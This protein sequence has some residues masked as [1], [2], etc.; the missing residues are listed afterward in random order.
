MLSTS[1]LTVRTQRPFTAVNIVELSIGF[2]VLNVNVS[3]S[4]GKSIT[5]VISFEY[6]Y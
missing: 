5:V 4:H 6:T 3:F 2:S 1:R